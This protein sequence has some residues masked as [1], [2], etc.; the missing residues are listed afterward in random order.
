MHRILLI[1]RRDYLATIRTKAF[2]IGLVVAPILFGGGFL[3]L[4]LMESKP[5]L[6]ERHIAILD[7][8]GVL[9]VAVIQAAQESNAKDMRDKKTGRQVQPRYVFETVAPAA[10][11]RAQRL[12]LSERVRREQL[13]AFV[14]INPSVLDPAQDAKGDEEK[15]DSAKDP[16][17]SQV[18]T[19]ANSGGFGEADRWLASAISDGVRKLRLAKLGVDRGQFKQILDSINIGRFGLVSR[20]EKTG[21]IHEASKKNEAAEFGIP[22]GLMLLLG[23][24][25][26]VGSSPMLSAVTEDKAQRLVEM[27]LG[28]AT[29][30]ELMI[31]KVVGALGVSLTSSAFYIIGGTLALEGMGMA[32]LVPFG[33]FPWFYVYLVTDVLFL[34]SLAAALGAGCNSPQEAQQLA[35]LLLAPVMIPYFMLTF[36]MQQPNGAISTA[37]S[38]FPPFTPMLMLLRQAL[39]GGVP[40]WQP[41]V[42][43]AGVL[44][45]TF[46]MVWAA[47]RIFRVA[48]LLQGKA[49]KVGDL[50]RWAI[51]G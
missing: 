49:P 11:A 1:A 25:V 16:A 47:A 44:I 22:F 38:L 27:L 4:A 36:V 28:M 23:M 21:E 12:A 19:F 40:A 15:K 5:D 13:Y 51:R 26:M 46:I 29:P 17:A 35:V 45:F 2:I 6:K 37:M 18:A 41:W 7:R 43:L 39:P 31:G 30:L 50:V 33:L 10:D 9:A 14:E 42:G 24:I 20:D 32:G 48:I 34:C 3:G 8:T